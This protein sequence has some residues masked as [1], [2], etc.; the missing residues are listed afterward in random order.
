MDLL[1]PDTIAF[2]AALGVRYTAGISSFPAILL[3]AMEELFYLGRARR[4]MRLHRFGFGSVDRRDGRV[5]EPVG[6]FSPA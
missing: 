1:I 5:V 3:R 2:V 6:D 4:D